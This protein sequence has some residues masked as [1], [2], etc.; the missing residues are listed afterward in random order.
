MLLPELYLSEGVVSVNL[1]AVF[2][3]V[4]I[5]IPFEKGIQFRREFSKA[6]MSMWSDTPLLGK[7]LYPSGSVHPIRRCDLCN[8]SGFDKDLA[9]WARIQIVARW[10]V[11]PSQRSPHQLRTLRTDR[12]YN[13]QQWSP[14]AETDGLT[15]TTLSLDRSLPPS[16]VHQDMTVL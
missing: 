5:R 7:L 12:F 8:A 9:L 13:V 11:Y 6:D 1:L 3:R 4:F 14:V 15:K 16:R 10:P 2:D